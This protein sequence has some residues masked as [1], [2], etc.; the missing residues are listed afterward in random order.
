MNWIKTSELKD[1]GLYVSHL[2]YFGYGM[3]VIQVVK[4]EDT[5]VQMKVVDN[6]A[7]FVNLA[8]DLVFLG[9]LPSP[10]CNW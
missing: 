5:F 4:I 9:P 7:V 10:P 8:H 6:K 1:Q 3:D 2:P